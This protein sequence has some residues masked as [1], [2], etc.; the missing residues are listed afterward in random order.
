VKRRVKADSMDPA[1]TCH[2][3]SVNK[4]VEQG[5]EVPDGCRELTI[6]QDEDEDPPDDLN[7]TDFS[8][9]FSTFPYHFLS[10]DLEQYTDLVL[11]QVPGLSSVIITVLIFEHSHLRVGLG[12]K[13]F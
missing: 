6:V 8:S 9:M 12:G 10:L 13:K 7:L 11:Y 2:D 4:A 3:P 5:V 1:E